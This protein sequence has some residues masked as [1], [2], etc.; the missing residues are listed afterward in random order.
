MAEFKDV[1][2]QQK[3]MCKTIEDCNKCPLRSMDHDCRLTAMIDADY[4]EAEV[5]AI[6]RI[7]MDWAAKNPE[8]RYPSWN[9]WQ[10]ANFPTAHNLMH[11]CAFMKREEAEKVCGVR[12]GQTS[13]NV[14]A[15]NPIPA[16]IAE[17]LGIKPIGGTEDA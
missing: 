15:R 14:C 17:K 7:V 13:C 3:R 16:E 11:P 2:K 9:E 1:V 12:C 10:K 5:E 4:D 8:S 6:E